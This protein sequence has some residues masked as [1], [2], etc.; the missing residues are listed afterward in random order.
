MNITKKPA[1]AA[2]P[3]AA[4]PRRGGRPSL[5]Q[6]ADIQVSILDAA[7]AL[8]LKTGF[9]STGIEAIAKRAGTSKA[10]VYARFSSKE[11]LFI[12][13]SNRVL[14]THFSPMVLSSGS[15]QERLN[16]L[17][18]QMLDALLDP[19][20]L[21][22]YRIIMAESER[23][24]ELARLSDNKSA[25]AGQ[26]LLETLLADEQAAGNLGNY[27]LAL[28]SQLF[29]ASVVLEPL[30]LESL[31]LRSFDMAA[32]RQW[33]DL[34]VNIFLNGCQQRQEL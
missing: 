15:L 4:K 13:V 34:V 28:L 29:I 31:G 20:I 7:E 26:D 8:F 3:R 2:T 16:D 10:T 17:A 5:Q 21:R 22:M 1:T 30:R 32:R 14:S 25:F 23:F 11:A 12:A 27:E 6:A 33:V 18:L 9:S 24:P 19:K